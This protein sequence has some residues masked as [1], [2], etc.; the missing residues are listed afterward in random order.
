MQQSDIKLG[1]TTY[2][3]GD[4][5]PVNVTDVTPK[6]RG[7]TVHYVT[8]DGHVGTLGARKFLSTCTLAPTP[9]DS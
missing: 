9:T 8:A 5:S 4:G 7:F 6:G 3:L 2:L 1:N